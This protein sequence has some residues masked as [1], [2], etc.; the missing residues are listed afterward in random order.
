MMQYF[1]RVLNK[2]RCF[3]MTLPVIAA[4][5]APDAF[6]QDAD[7]GTGQPLVYGP[8]IGLTSSGFYEGFLNG[9]QHTGSVTG[10]AVGGFASYSLLDFLDVSA[11]LMYMQQGG[12]RVELKESIVDGSLI[13]TTGNV[14]L[15]NVEF[16]VLVRLGMPNPVLGIRPQLVFGPSVGFNVAAIQSQDITYFVDA[17]NETP[18]GLETFARTGSGTENV[19]SE[20]RSMQYGLNVGLG[21]KIPLEGGSNTFFFD[22]RYRYGVN[23]INNGYDPNDLLRDATDIRSNTFL[24]SIGITL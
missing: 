14:K 10:V 16:P 3:A 13:T 2:A 9:R 11:E 12:T 18:A 4:L 20:Y 1:N 7:S 15:H 22:A 19:R 5:S 23:A 21:A 17:F 6:A 8:K 24:F